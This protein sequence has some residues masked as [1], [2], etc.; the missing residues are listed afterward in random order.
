MKRI[1]LDKYDSAGVFPDGRTK[2][3]AYFHSSDGEKYV[4]TPEWKG[5]T[6]NFFREAFEVEKLNISELRERSVVTQSSEA[7]IRVTVQEEP[8]EKKIDFEPIALRLGEGLRHQV[9]SERIDKA[10][11]AV[12]NFKATLH[13]YDKITSIHSQTIF[14]WIMTLSDQPIREEHKLRLLRQFIGSLTSKVVEED[15]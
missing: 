7:Q 3:N 10:A 12:F 1:F 8:E 13:P 6:N 15:K 11:K 4:W 9:S 14:D 2:L 5:E